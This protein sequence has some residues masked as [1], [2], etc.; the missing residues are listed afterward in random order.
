MSDE[1]ALVVKNEQAIDR[2]GVQVKTG[3]E[4]YALAEMVVASKQF[5]KWKNEHQ[6]AVAIQTGLELGL[7]PVRALKALYVPPN[8]E[9]EISGVALGGLIQNH[10]ESYEVFV[11]GKGDSRVGHCICQRRGREEVRTSFSVEDAK[12]AGLWGKSNW[13]NYPDDMLIWRAVSRMGKRYFADVTLGLEV[14]E[15]MGVERKRLEPSRAVP[16]V[17]EHDPILDPEPVSSP[18][19]DAGCKSAAVP[20]A[21]SVSDSN[22]AGGG[23]PGAPAT[24]FED[25]PDY[26]VP[27][28]PFGCPECALPV[29]AEGELCENCR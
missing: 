25:P 21:T 7:T 20:S 26:T 3:R 14:H 4:L 6:A 8:G 9:P 5:T 16:V 10:C 15:I 27:E 2:A 12:Q 29:S 24:L 11:D 17:V 23:S 19:A 28:K 13:K 22:T 1:T 18:E